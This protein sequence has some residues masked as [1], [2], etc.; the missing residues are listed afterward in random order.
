MSQEMTLKYDCLLMTKHRGSR[1]TLWR[2]SIHA[3]IWTT[4]KQFLSIS[5]KRRFNNLRKVNTKPKH[6]CAQLSC[7]GLPKFCQMG[8]RRRKQ[9]EATAH[10]ELQN[11]ERT[12]GHQSWIW[13]LCVTELEASYRLLPGLPSSHYTLEINLFTI[14]SLVFGGRREYWCLQY[15]NL[16]QNINEMIHNTFYMTL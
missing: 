13:W 2:H 11:A 10:G 8:N 9:P 4:L 6:R 5:D 15:S 1:N 12:P 14:F 7:R 16:L 3:F